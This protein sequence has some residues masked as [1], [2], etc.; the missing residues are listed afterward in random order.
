MLRTCAKSL[1]LPSVP[2][3]LP[4]STQVV[5]RHMLHQS[6]WP[7]EVTALACVT[8]LLVALAISPEFQRTLRLWILHRPEHRL[9][10]AESFAIRRRI[11]AATAGRRWSQTG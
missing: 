11:R 5:V 6:G 7:W 3:V 1:A 9:A 4:V 8:S 10:A 2:A